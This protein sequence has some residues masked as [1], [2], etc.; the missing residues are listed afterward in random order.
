MRKLILWLLLCPLLL[1]PLVLFIGSGNSAQEVESILYFALELSKSEPQPKESI[2]RLLG[3]G[4]LLFVLIS[5]FVVLL[6]F[7]N[8]K[9]GVQK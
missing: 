1:L 7:A 6:G 3:L 8:K 4:G 9:L 5:V 2:W